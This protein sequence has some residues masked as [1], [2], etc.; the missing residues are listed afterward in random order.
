MEEKLSIVRRLYC[1]DEPGAVDALIA[2][3]EALRREYQA[4]A[5]V[6]FHLDQRPRQ[7]PDA[8]ALDAV[9][10]AAEGG[11]SEW[12]E[13]RDRP[14]VPRR[15]RRGLRALGVVSSLCV[16]LA[17]GVLG[18]SYFRIA[19]HSDPPAAPL[20]KMAPS[21]QSTPPPVPVEQPEILDALED[22][23]EQVDAGVEIASASTSSEKVAPRK[24]AKASSRRPTPVALQWDESAE[25]RKLYRR[26]GFIE[27]RSTTTVWDQPAQSSS[28]VGGV[29]NLQDVNWDY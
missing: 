25:V 18:F 14:A 17:V 11:G 19:T 20:S 2:Q 27:A 9:F 22:S 15:A 21:A 10:A 13:R 29:P 23:G 24:T 7:R 1:E 3:D 12:G 4:L 5:E 8:R 28:S 26:A 6:K 16:A